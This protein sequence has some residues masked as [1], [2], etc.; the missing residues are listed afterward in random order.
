MTIQN[1]MRLAE[2]DRSG[3]PGLL[4]EW[5]QSSD[6]MLDLA[7]VSFD[8]GTPGGDEGQRFVDLVLEANA[9]HRVLF[10][11]A[12][13]VGPI[14]FRAAQWTAETV[15]MR[16]T[17][18]SVVV[19]DGCEFVGST[20]RFVAG[21]V[22]RGS[23]RQVRF[24]P[25]TQIACIFEFEGAF[26]DSVLGAETDFECEWQNCTAS[27]RGVQFGAISTRF[28]SNE[29]ADV[30]F[31]G[32]RVSDGALVEFDD[33]LF[34]GELIV[35]N[36]SGNPRFVIELNRVMRT[37]DTGVRIDEDQTVLD[38]FVNAFN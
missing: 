2:H 33:N 29:F 15:E 30:D 16:M 5:A 38:P 23:L 32:V 14:H 1:P 36:I 13:F 17:D 3:W 28:T 21:R 10:S 7:G 4:D 24:P 19:F 6:V 12:V 11:G 27:L 35:A 34:G 26:D 37:T 31:S 9:L 18:F 25:I 22:G 20:F 8:Q